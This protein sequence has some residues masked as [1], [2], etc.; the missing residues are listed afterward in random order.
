MKQ[1]TFEILRNKLAA[2]VSA[3]TKKAELINLICD[4]LHDDVYTVKQVSDI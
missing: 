2:K 1:R 4:Q 3:N